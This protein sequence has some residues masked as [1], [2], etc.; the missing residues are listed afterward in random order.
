MIHRKLYSTYT[1]E[2]R[3]KGSVPVAELSMLATGVFARYARRDVILVQAHCLWR[4]LS[5]KRYG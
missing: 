5:A 4:W 3:S 1:V 2:I